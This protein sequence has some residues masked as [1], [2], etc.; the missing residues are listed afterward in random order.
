VA[1]ILVLVTLYG[2]NDGLN[3]VVPYLDGTYHAARPNLGYAPDGVLPLADGLGFNSALKGMKDLWDRGHLAIVRGVGYPDPSLS[4]FQSMDIW[5]TGS[6]DGSGSGWLGRWLDLTGSDPMRAIS[7]GPILPLALRG[8]RSSA[9]AVDGPTIRLP[10]RP[11]V[12]AALSALVR[13]GPDRVGLA[14][15][16]A[17]S[18][19]DL[20]VVQAELDRLAPGPGGSGGRNPGSSRATARQPA[21]AGASP[22]ADQLATVAE[23]IVAGAPTRLYQVSLSSFDTHAD[24]KATHERLLGQL[25]GAVSG[26]FQAIQQAPTAAGV[27]LATYSEFGR[28]VS[29]NASGGTDHGSAAPLFVAGQ[30]VNGGRFYGDEPSLTD[31]DSSGNLKPTTDFRSVYATLLEQVLG[32][33]SR[34]V[35][36]ASFPSIALL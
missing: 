1:T 9:T 27:V 17:G 36:G 14:A 8:S 21:S 29:E 13:P 31:L 15:D 12:R 3:T 24:E 23:L 2:G 30:R 4:H 11:E 34:A 10:G 5:Q 20:L 6:L 26:F 18:G 25:D 33:D 22:L 32:T 16:V 19:R 35:L 7:I 28:R